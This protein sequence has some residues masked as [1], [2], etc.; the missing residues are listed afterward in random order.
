MGIEEL[1]RRQR[2]RTARCRQGQ[3][4]LRAKRL[5]LPL[6]QGLHPIE[7]LLHRRPW[8]ERGLQHTD[9]GAQ[10]PERVIDRKIGQTGLLAQQKRLLL[11]HLGQPLQLRASGSDRL[12]RRQ[13]GLTATHGL[14][15]L[16]ERLPLTGTHLPI[17]MRR[18]SGLKAKGAHHRKPPH[19]DNNTFQ[20]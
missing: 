10:K 3:R 9:L 2:S 12:C 18:T 20:I 8:I 7:P 6:A 5:G 16:L 14:A 4:R 15:V 19:Q 17:K 11:Q 13:A 1:A